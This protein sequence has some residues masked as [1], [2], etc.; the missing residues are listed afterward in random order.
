MGTRV[1]LV[2][3]EGGVSGRDK[4]QSEMWAPNQRMGGPTLHPAS[5]ACPAPLPTTKP[6]AQLSQPQR[7]TLLKTACSCS[8]HTIMGAERLS[9]TVWSEVVTLNAAKGAPGL[10]RTF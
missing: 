1:L 6:G 10:A 8:L 5:T 9:P 2:I 3:G 4:I 7:I